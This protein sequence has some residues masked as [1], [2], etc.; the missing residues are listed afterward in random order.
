MFLSLYAISFQHLYK[1]PSG[2]INIELSETA[3][4]TPNLVDILLFNLKF[5]FFNSL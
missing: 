5:L 3:P 2:S 4:H 1:S